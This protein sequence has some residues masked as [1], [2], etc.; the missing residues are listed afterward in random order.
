MRIKFKRLKKIKG[1]DIEK[2]VIL[3]IVLANYFKYLKN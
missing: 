3:Y 2:S 1:D